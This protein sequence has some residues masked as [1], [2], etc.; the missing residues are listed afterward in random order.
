ME[1]DTKDIIGNFDG[2]FENHAHGWAFRPGQPGRRLEVE[3][4][5]DGV[6]VN[7]GLA[8]IFREDLPQAGVGDGQHHFRIPVPPGLFD[9]QVHVLN[10]REAE[11]GVYL[12]GGPHLVSLQDRPGGSEAAETTI[13][14]SVSSQSAILH[15]TG[16][17][18]GIYDDHVHGWA[19][20][21]D[22]PERRLVVEIISNGNV[23]A[24]DTADLFRDD[25][26]KAG[27]GDAHH[28]FC[29]PVSP[30]LFTDQVHFLSARIP[31]C[32]EELPGGP[33]A[34]RR[35]KIQGFLEF[36]TDGKALGWAFD[37][38]R[39]QDRVEVEI[40]CVDDT[41]DPFVVAHGNADLFRQD[42][43]DA[44]IDDGRR[45]FNLSLSR[46]MFDGREHSLQAR[47]ART[48]QIFNQV[49]L[50]FQAE[51]LESAFD[52]LPRIQF[53]EMLRERLTGGDHLA[54]ART[55]R[56]HVA[57]LDRACLLMETDQ[58]AE[59]RKAFTSLIETI[60]DNAPCQCKIGETWLLQGQPESALEAYQRAVELD[61]TLPWAYRGLGHALRESGRFVEAEDAFR[62]AC[63]LQPEDPTP[64]KW[65]R[66]IEAHSLPA[67]ADELIAQGKTEEAVHMLKIRLLHDPE[68][69]LVAD[70]LVQLLSE[71]DSGVIDSSLPGARELREAEHARILLN[72]I[73]D[74]DAAM[75]NR[76]EPNEAT[77]GEAP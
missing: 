8:D 30:E 67:R 5:D 52:L 26:R 6:V 36:L 59:A 13:Q 35:S 12:P 27:I 75:V 47:D 63:A 53:L 64:R 4:V 11:S 51:C 14:D 77:Q 43:L 22:H 45:H 39:P 17:F 18:D 69:Q 42:L 38:V 25:L 46:E 76:G 23:V 49:P 1:H 68:S 15:C 66:D 48:G 34:F 2:V 65:L 73:L 44:G 24:R 60:G 70:R 9:G 20:A 56:T 41:G 62:R 61:A 7:K 10:V 37:P 71:A 3:I 74:E 57:N 54:A 31:E 58:F 32:D 21:P 16:K 50:K 29:I 72:V 28:H 19:Y 40:V 55:T 33:H